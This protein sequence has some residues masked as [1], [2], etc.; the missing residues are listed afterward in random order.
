MG[1]RTLIE[2]TYE[3]SITKN[4]R[5]LYRRVEDASGDPSQRTEKKAGGA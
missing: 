2:V 3:N 4:D 5:T 1:K